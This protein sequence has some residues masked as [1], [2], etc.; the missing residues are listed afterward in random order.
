MPKSVLFDRDKII[1][2]VTDLFWQKGYKG[3]SMQDL[4]DITGLNR[5][6]FYNSFGDKFQLFEESIR[7]YQKIQNEIFG[8]AFAKEESPKQGIISLFE[9]IRDEIRTNETN[10][11]CFI[12]NSTAEFGNT[13]DRIYDFLR[14]N[15]KSA[16]SLFEMLIIKA[17]EA[18]EID[19]SKDARELG[20]YL[21]SS[22][23]GLQVTS[24]IEPNVEGVTKEILASL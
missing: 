16:V 18:G 20:L 12:T 11:G 13:D 14:E 8:R 6:S 19:S 7:S 9:D 22:L 3:T 1:Q 24:M 5:S 21:F 2:K 4:V 15:M 23:Q 17:Q 10:H